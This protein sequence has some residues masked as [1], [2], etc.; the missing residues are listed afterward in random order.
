M[1]RWPVQE[2]VGIAFMTIS[3]STWMSLSGETKVINERDLVTRSVPW[4][5]S[6][7]D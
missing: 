1:S 6:N 7:M 5:S 3:S 2:V 4:W